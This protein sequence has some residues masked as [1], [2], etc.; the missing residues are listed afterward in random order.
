MKNYFWGVTFFACFQDTM[1]CSFEPQSQVYKHLTEFSG[2]FAFI[3]SSKGQ[4]LI[5]VQSFWVENMVQNSIF[6]PGKIMNFL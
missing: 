2:F 1:I 5:F 6:Q 3:L 4:N